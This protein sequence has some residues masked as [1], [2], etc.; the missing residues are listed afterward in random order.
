MSHTSSAAW[1][2]LLH[3]TLAER[4]K[5]L[6]EIFSSTIESAK[7]SVPLAIAPTKTQMLSFGPNVSTNSR[8]RTSGASKLR[9]TF[10]QFG[11]RWSVMG[12]WITRSSFSLEFVDRIDRRWRSWTIRPANRLKVRGMRTE[13]DT[14]MSTPLA[15]WMYIWSL[16][17]LLMGESRSVSRHWTSQLV[18]HRR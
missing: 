13:G 7:L 10:R 16:P 14:S 15:V 9:V 18:Y 6:M 2:N 4:E 5:L 12:F 1:Q 11:G 17:A 8:T 3:A